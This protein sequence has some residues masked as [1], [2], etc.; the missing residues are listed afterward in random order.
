MINRPQSMKCYYVYMAS[1]HFNKPNCKFIKPKRNEE[2]L[3]KCA[4]RGILK[5]K[6]LYMRLFITVG[7]IFKSFAFMNFVVIFYKIQMILMFSM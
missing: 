6:L 5:E 3:T 1:K 2:F 4:Y 7:K